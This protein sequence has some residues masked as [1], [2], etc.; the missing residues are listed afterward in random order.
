MGSPEAGVPQ[1]PIGPW[2][3][4]NPPTPSGNTAQDARESE[5]SAPQPSPPGVQE[6]VSKPTTAEER[7]AAAEQREKDDLVAQETSAAAAEG[8]LVV[9]WGQLLLGTLGAVALFAALIQQTRA[10]RAAIEANRI[11]REAYIAEQRP[12]ITIKPVAGGELAVDENGAVGFVHVILKN[13]GKS[14][15]ESVYLV[16][17]TIPMETKIS[18][19]TMK[20]LHDEMQ[21]PEIGYN[22]ATLL[23][24]ETNVIFNMVST[25]GQNLSK[26]KLAP[27]EP[28]LAIMY[29]VAV[30][31]R[32][33]VKSTQHA[34]IRTYI[35][36]STKG[37][38]GI[39]IPISIEEIA[40]KDWS[41]RGCQGGIT[42]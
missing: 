32:S 21:T 28:L 24:G 36:Q 34:T 18:H 12:W 13:I 17:R 41:F 42:E 15:A 8:M 22:F 9:A 19:N 11:N 38:I 33:R 4:V 27:N 6:G 25:L 30:T 37:E 23:P 20:R 7:E 10:T 2:V 1:P 39:D 26:Y 5:R 3:A 16:C 31:Y 35:V 40:A 14:P 29:V